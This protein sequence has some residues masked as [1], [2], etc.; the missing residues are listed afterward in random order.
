MTSLKCKSKS[1]MAQINEWLWSSEVEFQVKPERRGH[2]HS[3]YGCGNVSASCGTALLLL[4]RSAFGTNTPNLCL[5][6]LHLVRHYAVWE[7]QQTLESKVAEILWTC[8]ENGRF[9]AYRE[10]ANCSPKIVSKTMTLIFYKT[11]IQL[12]Y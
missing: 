5:F 4:R 1:T 10:Q 9:M 8:A 11:K 7:H 12:N 3:F 2:W 6:S